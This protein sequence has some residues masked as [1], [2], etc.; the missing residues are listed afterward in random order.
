MGL[1]RVL[2]KDDRP[3]LILMIVIGFEKLAVDG[4]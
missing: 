3:D 4:S 1:L 2:G